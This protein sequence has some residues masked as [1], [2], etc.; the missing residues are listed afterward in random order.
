VPKLAEHHVKLSAIKRQVFHVGLEEFDDHLSQ[1]SI[2]ASALQ[3][4]RSQ[5]GGFQ[6]RSKPR[7]GDGHDSGSAADVQYAH[8]RGDIGKL[9]Q[10][11]RG[12]RRHRF[13]RSEVLPAFFLYLFELIES[14][15]TAFLLDA[16]VEA[17][18]LP[19]PEPSRRA[20]HPSDA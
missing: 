11:R 7:S 6:L 16:Y 12:R 5:I 20:V 14:F 9:H 18:I 3:K 19:R 4:L 15:H 13:Q 1:P 8:T 2:L 17:A 10:A